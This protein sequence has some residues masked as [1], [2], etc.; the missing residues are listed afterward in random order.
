MGEGN[1]FVNMLEWPAIERLLQ[2]RKGERLL[3]IA[4]GNGLTSRRLARTGADGLAFDFSETMIAIAI[5]MGEVEDRGGTVV[6]TYSV[7]T[8][9]Y[10]TSFTQSG[11]AIPGQPVPHPYFHRSLSTLLGAAFKAGFVLA[12]IEEPAFSPEYTAG[13]LPISWNGRFSEIP[14]VLVARLVRSEPRLLTGS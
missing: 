1:D 7:K 8:S 11:V 2:P 12:A 6:T 9:R 5:M 3:D 13:S 4:C 14:P 10:L